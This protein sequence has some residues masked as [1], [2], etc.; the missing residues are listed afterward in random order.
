LVAESPK[1]RLFHCILE[2]N[3]HRIHVFSRAN[4][5][6]DYWQDL[7]QEILLRIWKGFDSYKGRAKTKTWIYAIAYNTLKEFIRKSDRLDATLES[8]ELHLK[9]RQSTYSTGESVDAFCTLEKFI[10]LLGDVDRT[11]LLMHLDGCTYQEISEATES[12]EGAQRVR[13]HRLKK[14]LAE[15]AGS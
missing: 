6:G 9:S 13:I 1:E 7:E 10:Q 11:A 3:R 12:D 8:L 14:Q 4:I 15:Y 5:R 2:E